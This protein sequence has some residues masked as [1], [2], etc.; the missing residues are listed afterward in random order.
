[1]KLVDMTVESFAGLL[2]SDAPAPGGGSA[3]ALAGALGASLCAMVARLTIGRKKYVSVED[4]MRSLVTGGEELSKELMLLVDEDT[5]AYNSVM[6]AFRMPKDNAVEVGARKAAIE[7]ASKTAT[8]VPLKTARLSLAVLELAVT[9]AEK[10]NSN[11]SSDAGVCALLAHAA[12]EGALYNVAINLP[13]IEDQ[14][15]VTAT[16]EE[17]DEIMSKA[18]L[19]ARKVGDTVMCYIAPQTT[20]Y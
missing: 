7:T 8:S 6:S 9:A 18:S 12:V 5:A 2:A 1:M 17:A 20:D 14:E 16:R 13:S 3:S 10:G 15:F 4:D 11:A 19:L